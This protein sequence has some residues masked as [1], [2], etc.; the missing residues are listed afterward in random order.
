MDQDVN[1]VGII[2]IENVVCVLAYFSDGH[3]NSFL[4][5]FGSSFKYIRK[6]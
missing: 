2:V 3:K 1:L 4:I 5:W 6:L